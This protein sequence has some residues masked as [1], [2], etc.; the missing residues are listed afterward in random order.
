MISAALKAWCETY[1]D[2]GDVVSPRKA[3]LY[4]R[5]LSAIPAAILGEA[6]KRATQICK[7]F[8]VPGDVL[9]HAEAIRCERRADTQR[10]NADC[11]ACDGTGW[12]YCAGG[13]VKPCHCRPAPP[14]LKSPRTPVAGLTHEINGEIAQAAA[15]KVLR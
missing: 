12:V 8:P 7:R 9:E 14:E 10:R 15:G 13:G 11:P 1:P 2:F 6:L 3:K 5:A 4:H